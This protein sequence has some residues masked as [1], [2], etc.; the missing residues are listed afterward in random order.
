M[1]FARLLRSAGLPVGPGDSLD[2]VRA[3]SVVDVTKREEFYWAL[4]A[5][6]VHRKSEHDVF[7]QAFRLYF[8]DPRGLDELLAMMLPTW[9]VPYEEVPQRDKVSRRLGEALAGPAPTRPKP[10]SEAPEIEVDATLTWSDTEVLRTKDFADM[11]SDEIRRAKAL[12]AKM[13]LGRTEVPTRRWKATARGARV[14]PRRTLRAAMRTGGVPVTLR[15]RARRGRIPPLVVLC[16]ISGSMERYSRILLHFLHALSNDR[17]RVHAFVFGTRLTPISRWLRHRDVDAALRSVGSNVD[18]WGG[19]TRIGAALRDFNRHWSR[20]VLTWGAV[21]LL[22]TD[23]LD[24]DDGSGLSFETERLHRSCRRLIWLNPLLSFSG[25]EPKA[26]GI[27]A[28]LPHVDELRPVHDLNSLE[29]LA[30]A[31][32]RPLGR[33]DRAPAGSG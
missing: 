12:I 18:D 23:G 21:V 13:R 14:D 7:D 8:R 17:D 33:R 3:L 20:R 28:I 2:G 6:F 15:R 4:H 11:S 16:D 22:I 5:V 27:R 1:H 25:F 26:G 24:R 29:D 32:A 19:G 10:R 31:L 9:T 30:E